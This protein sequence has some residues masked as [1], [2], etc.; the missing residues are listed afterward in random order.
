MLSFYIL[1]LFM[2]YCKDT[3]STDLKIRELRGHNG[4]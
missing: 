1:Y 4:L 2:L 3:N